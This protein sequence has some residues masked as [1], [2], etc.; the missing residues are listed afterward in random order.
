M[1]FRRRKSRVLHA[2]W[3]KSDFVEEAVCEAQGSLALHALNMETNGLSQRSGG[4]YTAGGALARIGI[5]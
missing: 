5:R 2:R 3:T 4:V 1:Q